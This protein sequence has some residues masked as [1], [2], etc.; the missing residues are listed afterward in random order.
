[1]VTHQVWVHASAFG[2][3]VRNL[4]L[5]WLAASFLPIALI[6]TG[7]AESVKIKSE[8]VDTEHMFG[9]T[10]GSEIGEKGET[11]LMSESTGRFGRVG[12]S[13]KQMTNLFEAKY[14]LTDRFRVSAGATLGYYGISDM[15]GLNVRDQAL[16]QSISF[17]A[18]YRVLDHQDAPFALTL[19]VEPSRS[20]VEGTSGA[21]ADGIGTQFAALAD[22]ELVADRLFGAF[23]LSYELE[24]TRL[25]GSPDI[26]RE[27]TFGMGAALTTLTGRGIFVGFE[28]RYFRHYEGLPLNNFVGQALYVGPTFYAKLG[29][30]AL[31]SAAWNTQAWGSASG[32]S[33][34]L[35]LV[36]FDRHQV[37][38]R[39]A[40]TY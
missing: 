18:R 39:F 30:H 25:H 19:S 27:A 5:A 38:L 31:I 26:S 11:E 10:E 21:R 24:R 22:R 15:A 36:H 8:E 20:F 13:Y 33:G 1:M 28:A 16:V 6:A 23:N 4:S 37:R 17:N 35:D 3:A 29:E 9:F 12:G 32:G 34:D 14:T 7:H 40:I 2:R